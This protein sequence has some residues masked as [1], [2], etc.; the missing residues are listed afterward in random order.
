MET[1]QSPFNNPTP[2]TTKLSQRKT[3]DDIKD[4]RYTN[5]TTKENAESEIYSSLINTTHSIDDILVLN[6]KGTTKLSL[7]R[8]EETES[9]VRFNHHSLDDIPESN[10][11]NKKEITKLSLRTDDGGPSSSFIHNLDD[12]PDGNY[13]GEEENSDDENGGAPELQSFLNDN[14]IDGNQIIDV[15]DEGNR[16]DNITITCP[17][18]LSLVLFLTYF[19][20][21]CSAITVVLIVEHNQPCDQPLYLWACI[22]LAILVLSLVV[23]IWTTTNQ[24]KRVTLDN[25]NLSLCWRIQ[26]RTAIFLQRIMNMFWSVWFL[27]GMVWTFKADTCSH[28]APSL[29]ILSLT[30]ISINLFLL[31]M[32]MLCCICAF[33]CFGIVYVVHP[34]AFGQQPNRG[35]TKKVIEKLETKKYKEG[36]LEDIEDAKCAICL[37]FYEEGDELRFLP[38]Q[39]KSHHFHRDCVDEWLQLNKACPFCKRSIDHEDHSIVP[40]DI[41]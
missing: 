13:V 8:K 41:V 19:I 9:P 16:E 32:C 3:E 37:S 1:N 2:P 7:L 31:G 20:G 34:E 27:I 40:P 15:Q 11:N 6:H 30:I 4:E 24:Y 25:Q 35:A 5:P 21:V 39:P 18:F 36:L 29:Y 22:Q 17:S 12:I 10:N 38:C 33:I 28:T 14:G 26:A 23:R